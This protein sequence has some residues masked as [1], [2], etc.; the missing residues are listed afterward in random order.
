M[1]PSSSTLPKSIEISDIL[2][3]SPSSP[4]MNSSRYCCS[5]PLQYFPLEASV[6]EVALGQE[7]T[8]PSGENWMSLHHDALISLSASKLAK[9][10]ISTHCEN[11]RTLPPPQAFITNWRPFVKS[12]ISTR[13]QRVVVRRSKVILQSAENSWGLRE[14]TSIASTAPMMDAY[15]FGVS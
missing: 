13:T 4:T 9:T 12:K 14:T 11:S 1:R 8:L 15:F 7:Y 6:P 10:S 5:P 3:S 2:T